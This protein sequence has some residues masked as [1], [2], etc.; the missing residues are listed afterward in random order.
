MLIKSTTLYAFYKSN[1]AVFLVVSNNC[2]NL[3]DAI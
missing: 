2:K 3:K 1:L